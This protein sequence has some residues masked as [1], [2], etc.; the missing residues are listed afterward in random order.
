M[1]VTWTQEGAA[2]TRRRT[3]EP[4]IVWVPRGLLLLLALLA[5]A[6]VEERAFPNPGHEAHLHRLPR[7]LP[8][9]PGGSVPN[10]CHPSVLSFWGAGVWKGESLHRWQQMYKMKASCK[11]QEGSKT[12]HAGTMQDLPGAGGGPGL[13]EFWGAGHGSGWVTW[14]CGPGVG[15]GAARMSLC[16][17]Y[18]RRQELLRTGKGARRALAAHLPPLGVDTMAL[19][20][21]GQKTACFGGL[22]IK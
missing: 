4:K 16:C 13:P 3:L 22:E 21:R 1:T 17:L 19:C 18:K 15:S 9:P 14:Q 20:C 10:P 8:R 7:L 5:G 6:G 2:G 11:Y 12:W